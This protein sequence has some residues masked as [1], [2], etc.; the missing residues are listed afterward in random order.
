MRILAAASLAAAALGPAAAAHAAPA[1]RIDQPCRVATGKTVEFSMV[2]SGWP[3]GAQVR[4]TLN[5]K[6][7][8]A[9]GAATARGEFTIPL[10]VD[11]PKAGQIER[12]LTLAVTDGTATARAQPFGVTRFLARY[13]GL[14]SAN[15]TRAR[16]RFELH[17]FIGSGPSA[18]L[19]Y[20]QPNGVVRRTVRLGALRG[21]CGS[22]RTSR[23]KVFPFGNLTVGV[24]TLVY[25]TRAAYRPRPAPPYVATPI[26]IFSTD[27]IKR[28]RRQKQ[29]GQKPTALCRTLLGQ[30]AAVPER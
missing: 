5:G 7:L 28:C 15:P 8:S 25:D 20:V 18:Y 19:H 16:G 21:P 14:T 23:R 22:L 24:W 12:R 6:R 29:L 9:R 26:P 30:A 1:V 10:I 4:F 13:A 3:A 17:G 11:A 27:D 2:G